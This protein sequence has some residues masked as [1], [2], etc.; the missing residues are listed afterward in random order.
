M[1]IITWKFRFQIKIFRVVGT[2]YQNLEVQSKLVFSPQIVAHDTTPTLP[3]WASCHR[4]Y[5]AIAIHIP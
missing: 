4:I 1:F 3:M 2:L 5:V